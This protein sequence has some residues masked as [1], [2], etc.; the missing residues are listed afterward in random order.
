[1][2][3][4][5]IEGNVDRVA[6]TE[7]DIQERDRLEALLSYSILDTAGQEEFDSLA[8]LACLVCETPVCLV[9]FIDQKRQWVKSSTGTQIT[10]MARKSSFCQYTILR[11]SVYEIG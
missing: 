2:V 8:D 3:K 7:F 6:A 5:L 11:K 1:M 9:T 10:E 4:G